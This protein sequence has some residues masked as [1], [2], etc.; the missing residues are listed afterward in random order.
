MVLT[1]IVKYTE[2][3]T[4]APMADALEAVGYD[5]IAS[6]VSVGRWPGSPP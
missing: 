5:W 1:G 3:N 4:A 2:L 6:L